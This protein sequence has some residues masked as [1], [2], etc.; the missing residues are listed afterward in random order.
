M[1]LHSYEALRERAAWIDLSNR[2]KIRVTGDD[3]VRLLHSMTTNHIQQLIPGS[4]CYTFFLTAQGRIIADANI[5][6]M[7]DYLL[8]DT[9]PETRQRVLEHLEKFIIAAD[10]LLHDFTNDYGTINLEGPT[11]EQF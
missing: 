4:G 6:C 1:D 7:S 3:R 11:A 8:I 2:G 9:E 10:V 5:F